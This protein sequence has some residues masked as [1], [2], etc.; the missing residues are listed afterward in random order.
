VTTDGGSPASR[1]H[2]G[3]NQITAFGGN[4]PTYDNNGSLTN[5]GT[6]SYAYDAWNML[7]AVKNAAGSSTIATYVYDAVNRRI[8]ESPTG[9]TASEQYYSANWQVLEEREGGTAKR[10]YVWSP[11]FVDALV[12]RD[13]DADNDGSHTLE[14]RL[15]AQQDANFNVTAVMN[16]SG[17]VQERYLYD[18]YGARTVSDASYGSRGGSSYAWEYGHQ[19]LR[20]D[21][22]TGLVYNRRRMLL[23]DLGRFIQVDPLL[24]INGSNMLEYE[25][26][27]P[28]INNDSEGLAWGPNAGT[29]KT[30]CEN[31]G[32]VYWG[33]TQ[34]SIGF[35]GIG[36]TINCCWCANMTAKPGAGCPPPQWPKP[37][38]VPKYPPSIKLFKDQIN[39]ALISPDKSA[40]DA[41]P[42]W[43]RQIASVYYEN[44]ANWIPRCGRQAPA[45]KPLSVKLNKDRSD[46]LIGKTD[47]PPG[48]LTGKGSDAEE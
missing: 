8:S 30:Y 20:H 13:R 6:Q 43:V 3:Q 2:N 15:Y 4:T 18:P 16:T 26:A 33:V 24:Y 12:L 45:L 19:G 14:E 44:V 1:T 22:A 46:F 29:C 48:D 5:D 25:G 27:N 28:T 36:I 32:D 9:G 41:L 21:V 34:K 17:A 31:L 35:C 7:V 37:C 11:V 39:K 23:P 38:D 47:T 10:Q 42:E 40:R